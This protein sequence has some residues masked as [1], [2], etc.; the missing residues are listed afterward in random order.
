MHGSNARHDATTVDRDTPYIP[1]PMAFPYR[2]NRITYYFPLAVRPCQTATTLRS[3][4]H[5]LQ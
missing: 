1:D 3:T 2:T 5:F 4:T